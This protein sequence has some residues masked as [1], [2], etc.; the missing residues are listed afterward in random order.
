MT[1]LSRC[2]CKI[3]IHAK[4]GPEDCTTCRILER[5]RRK[6]I[7]AKETNKADMTARGVNEARIPFIDWRKA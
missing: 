7:Q 6:L 2:K 4:G 5:R 3:E 1:R